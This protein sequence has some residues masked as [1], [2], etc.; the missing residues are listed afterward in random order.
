MKFRLGLFWFWLS[1]KIAKIFLCFNNFYTKRFFFLTENDYI[2]I[3]FR[4]GE[5]KGKGGTLKYNLRPTFFLI[6]KKCFVL[7]FFNEKTYA[8]IFV[9]QR[10]CLFLHSDLKVKPFN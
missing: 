8:K 5:H 10:K 6:V 4:E 3:V 2:C 7:I 9:I 1:V